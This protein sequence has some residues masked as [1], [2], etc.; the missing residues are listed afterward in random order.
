MK[1]PQYNVT[2]A[3]TTPE[4]RPKGLEV[5]GGD[6]GVMQTK[7]NPP[8]VY[9]PDTSSIAR[10]GRQLA[11]GIGS[12]VG[13]INKAKEDLYEDSQWRKIHTAAAQAASDVMTGSIIDWEDENS[14]AN[15][16]QYVVEQVKNSVDNDKE[17][18]KW[19]SRANNN[20]DKKLEEFLHSTIPTFVTYKGKAVRKILDQR[21][22][23]NFNANNTDAFN[24]FKD[25]YNT[26]G[27]SANPYLNMAAYDYQRASENP[28]RTNQYGS[29]MHTI[30]TTIENQTRTLN[31]MQK[32]VKYKMFSATDYVV[33][34]NALQTDA[35]NTFYVVNAPIVIDEYLAKGDIAGAYAFYNAV[36]SDNAWHDT[37]FITTWDELTGQTKVTTVTKSQVDAYNNAHSKEPPISLDMYASL[38]CEEIE[39]TSAK[40]GKRLRAEWST[41][42][43]LGE[44][45]KIDEAKVKARTAIERAKPKQEDDKVGQLVNF[46]ANV[47]YFNSLPESVKRMPGVRERVFKNG[48]NGLTAAELNIVNGTNK[49]V[50]KTYSTPPSADNLK[51]GLDKMAK[52][53]EKLKGGSNAKK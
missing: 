27:I 34:A 48:K 17:Y 16:Q 38:Q 15:A 21:V 11:K 44:V 9:Q 49:P 12:V 14:V 30:A 6:Y 19:Y 41:P 13:A 32:D 10:A 37:A 39:A 28:L 7:L 40:D 5:K 18:N 52:D 3:Q 50:G 22:E 53:L 24:T 33:K 26:H 47:E 23:E 36:Y 51:D 35:L 45:E 20:N 8:Y 2:A 1:M 25:I 42:A 46:M 29:P 4:N 31:T 43:Q